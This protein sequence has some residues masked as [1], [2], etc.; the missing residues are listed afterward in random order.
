MKL[1]FTWIYPGVAERP[2]VPFRVEG[3]PPGINLMAL[4][5]SGAMKTML[6]ARIADAAGIPLP[7]QVSQRV[8]IGGLQHDTFSARVPIVVGQHKW[9]SDVLFAQGWNAP[10]QIF[11]LSDLFELFRVHVDTEDKTTT[12]SP[13]RMSPRISRVRK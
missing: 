2:F 6:D 5:D 13:K 8:V 7:T 3:I 10:H 12:I 1:P 9:E 4:V 11:G